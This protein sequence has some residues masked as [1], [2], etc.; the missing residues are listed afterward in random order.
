MYQGLTCTWPTHQPAS[1]KLTMHPAVFEKKAREDKRDKTLLDWHYYTSPTT[2]IPGSP[3]LSLSGCS[4]SK[5]FICR[6]TPRKN[7]GKELKSWQ[8]RQHSVIVWMHVMLPLIK[9]YLSKVDCWRFFYKFCAIR[10]WGVVGVSLL[11]GGGELLLY[12]KFV[13]PGLDWYQDNHRGSEHPGNSGMVN[14]PQVIYQ[15]CILSKLLQLSH[16]TLQAWIKVHV[17]QDSARQPRLK[18]AV[19]NLETFPCLGSTAV[20]W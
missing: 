10:R 5:D 3:S 13:T 18:L 15:P 19:Y 20:S 16:K 8:Q 12:F 9:G 14:F 7:P 17:L 6:R 4:V 1:P 11:R 2:P